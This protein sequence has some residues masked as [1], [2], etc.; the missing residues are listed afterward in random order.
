MRRALSIDPKQP[1]AHA[2]LGQLLARAGR[3]G[4]ARHHMLRAA[5]GGAS[6]VGA[7]RW[8]VDDAIGGPETSSAVFAV[9]E[10]ARTAAVD[11]ATLRDIGQHLLE[12]RRGDLAEPYFL[13]LDARHPRRADIVEALGVAL[14]E[15]GQSA[16][17]AKT[18]E[19]AVGLDD[20]RPSSHLHLAIAYVQIDRLEDA[21]AEAR[22][23]LALRPTIPR[24]GASSRRSPGRSE[25]P[26]RGCGGPGMNPAASRGVTL[27]D[28]GAD[29]SHSSGSRRGSVDVSDS[30]H[31]IQALAGSSRERPSASM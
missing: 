1:E 16:R 27:M 17:A 14:L 31:A 3:T 9:A 20:A 11:A 5:A 23:A 26:R 25:R 12:A 21:L 28:G 10:V 24:L 18:L 30:G 22:R 4:E 19:R 2:V 8:I 7:A 15:R 13:A 6:A 29:G